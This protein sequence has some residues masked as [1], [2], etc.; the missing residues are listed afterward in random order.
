MLPL[1]LQQT[2]NAIFVFFL[3]KPKKDDIRIKRLKMTLSH[4]FAKKKKTLHR[5]SV[6]V[7]ISSYQFR[8]A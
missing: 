1:Y 6:I 2:F 3:P 7:T 5:K 4:G 8:D